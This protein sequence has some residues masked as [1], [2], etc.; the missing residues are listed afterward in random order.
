MESSS[1]GREAGSLRDHPKNHVM[2]ARE[3][4]VNNTGS[5]Q[6]HPT[7]TE[8]SVAKPTIPQ[9]GTIPQNIHETENLTEG[10]ISPPA[11]SHSDSLGN[12]QSSSATGDPRGKGKGRAVT[13]EDVAEDL[14]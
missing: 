11:V 4:D 6:K 1:F 8:T 2:V 5:G 13:I 10:A 9:L 14:D 3:G 12:G 7:S